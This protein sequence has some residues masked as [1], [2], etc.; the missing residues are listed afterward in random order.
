MNCVYKFFFNAQYYQ[1]GDI[2]GKNNRVATM[3]RLKPETREALENVA[4]NNN[5]S[6]NSVIN[7][8]LEKST[9]KNINIYNIETVNVYT[10]KKDTSTFDN[11]V[12]VPYDVSK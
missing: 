7:N 8:L 12:D 10:S 2:M 3:I 4:E 5:T 6:L 11:F 9:A 1:G